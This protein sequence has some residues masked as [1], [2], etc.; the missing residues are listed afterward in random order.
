M[1]KFKQINF[2][3]IGCGIAGGKH[4]LAISKA[5]NT[6]LVAVCSKSNSSAIKLA[7]KYEG[8]IV[9]D[10]NEIIKSKKI[11]VLCI[12]SPNFYH[13]EQVLYAV[14]NEKHVIVEK[15]LAMDIISAQNILSLSKKNNVL[16]S[17]VFPRRFDKTWSTIYELFMNK[18]LGEIRIITLEQ[19]YYRSNDYY[20]NSNWHGKKELDGGILLT[21]GIHY[22]DLLANLISAS[23]PNDQIKFDQIFINTIGTKTKNIIEFPD[24][25]FSQFLIKNKVIGS[26]HI[27]TSAYPGWNSRVFISCKQGSMVIADDTITSWGIDNVLKPTGGTNGWNGTSVT[28]IIN[29]MINS[30]TYNLP[31]KF[32][33]QSAIDSLDF[34]LNLN[35]QRIVI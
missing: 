35:R 19:F 31:L 9:M 3:I 32:D 10:V 1:T 15:P 16:V 29:D 21:Q 27:S 7:S 11:D 8:T 24:T 34:A 5:K 26:I 4:A 17:V 25:V 30:L 22:I 28:P 13:S 2:G 12:C 33:L 20:K 14:S 18:I 6:K 23:Y